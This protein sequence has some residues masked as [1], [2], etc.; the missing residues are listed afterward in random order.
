MSCSRE[1][2]VSVDRGATSPDI[3][4]RVEDL[5]GGLSS[6]VVDSPRHVQTPSVTYA[7]RRVA[8]TIVH[9]R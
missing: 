1:L 2:V 7:A 8:A 4:S 9:A 3:H 5:E 6:G